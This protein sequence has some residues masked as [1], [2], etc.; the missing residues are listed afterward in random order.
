[1]NTTPRNSSIEL[2]RIVLMMMITLHHCIYHGIGLY[3]PGSEGLPDYYLLVLIEALTLPAVNCFVF[4]SGYYGIRLR[5]RTLYRIL[6]A[7]L[8]YTLLCNSIPLIYSGRYTEAA[9]QLLALSHTTYWFLREYVFLLVV[10]PMVNKVFDLPEGQRRCVIISFVVITGYF[11]FLWYETSNSTGL[12]LCQFITMYLIGGEIRRRGIQW[13]MPTSC[14]VLAVSTLATAI[15]MSGYGWEVRL[16]PQWSRYNNPLLM[17]AAVSLFMIFANMNF[18]SPRVNSAARSALAIYLVQDSMLGNLTFYSWIGRWYAETGG[19]T[20]FY[21][22]MTGS[23]LV[24]M[25]AALY[26]DRIRLLLSE[27][28]WRKITERFPR[29]ESMV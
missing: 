26:F 25:A 10:T 27:K 16:Y 14:I 5:W 7:M 3:N 23:S 9:L 11:G 13:S 17:L 24:L 21:A 15:L 20:L 19:H 4:V 6:F 22:V 2:L 29:A 12:S 28:L 1:M 8:F 18:S